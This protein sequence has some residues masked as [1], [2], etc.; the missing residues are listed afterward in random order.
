MKKKTLHMIGNAHIDP[1]WLWRRQEGFREVLATFRSALDRMEEYPEFIFTCSSAAFYEWVE[2][3]DPPMFDEIRTRVREGR[4]KIV[5]GWWIQPDCNLP[6]G[7]SFVRQ[8]LLGQRYFKRTFGATA[9]SGYN[10]DSFGHSAMLPQLLSK[11]GLKRYVFMRPGDH[12]KSL[13]APLFRWES[14]DGSRVLAYRIPLSYTTAGGEISEHMRGTASLFDAANA[15]LMCFYGVGNHGGGPT[16]V[17]LDSIRRVRDRE[18]GIEVVMSSPDAFFDRVEGSGSV[19]PVV[20]DELQHHARGCYSAHSEVK[21]LNRMAEQR[22]LA[23]ER[24]EVVSSIIPRPTRR[25]GLGDKPLEDLGRAWK[26]VLFNQFHDILAGTALESAYDD[27]R[28]SYGEALSI[29]ARSLNRSLAAIERSVEIPIEEGTVPVFVF[30]PNTFPVREIAELEFMHPGQVGESALRPNDLV[31]DEAGASVPFQRI[32]SEAT[33]QGRTRI[34][35]AAALPP[36][37]Y[38][39]YRVGPGRP[40][41]GAAATPRGEPTPPIGAELAVGDSSIE[42]A[43]LRLEL[44]RR[45]GGVGRLYDKVGQWEVVGGA[46]HQAACGVVY[47]DESD[48]WSH[49]VDRYADVLGAFECRELAIMERGPVRAVVRSVAVYG[50][51][52]LIEDFILERSS[53][54]VDVR[55]TLDWHEQASVLKLELPLNLSSCVATY[56]IPYGTVTRPVGSGEEPGQG[57]VDLS[58]EAAGAAPEVRGIERGEKA[59]R[60]LSIAVDAK[61]SYSVDGATLSFIAARSPIYAHHAPLV[62]AERGDYRFMDQGEQRFR[63]RLIPHSTGWWGAGTVHLAA[64]LAYPPVARLASFHDGTLP[65]HASFLEVDPSSIMVTALKRAEEGDAVILRCYEPFGERTRARIRIERL[66]CAIEAEF[67]P[68]EIKTF[69]ILPS[70]SVEEVDLLEEA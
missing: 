13:P 30:N 18:H 62:P 52:T 59:A 7:E 6:C 40:S 15:E 36:L 50:S 57:W 54:F 24:L 12:E 42:N 55:V 38:R 34:C 47:R 45:S 35:F 28:E 21:R 4:W 11:M 64:A 2:Q 20:R 22:L 19:L 63:Y 70:G 29:S 26:E 5:G 53:A 43:F 17:N 56:E 25:P 32:Q 9:T 58:G 41:G 69:R 61:Q 16:K 31:T 37:G 23:A 33:V 27:V 60:G 44:D 48:T 1:V 39:V 66:R 67:A 46:A 49:D 10:V 8:G 3:I 14:V 51:S 68:H 65:R